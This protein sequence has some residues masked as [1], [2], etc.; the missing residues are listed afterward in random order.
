MAEIGS[1]RT[2]NRLRQLAVFLPNRIGMLL[3]LH[4][5]LDAEDL[6]ILGLTVVDAADHAVARLVVDQ[7]T[8]AAAALRA[9][10][11]PLVESEVIGVAFGSETGFKRVLTAVLAAEVNI[12]YVYPLLGPIRGRSVLVIQVD[13]PIGAARLLSER[14]LELVDQGEFQPP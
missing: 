12:H 10:G 9:A 8:L 3:A 7:P 4:R 11:H 5:T 14:G 6:R 1:D 2:G 13:D